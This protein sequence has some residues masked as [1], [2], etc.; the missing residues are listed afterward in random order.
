MNNEDA[1]RIADRMTYREAI[2]NCFYAKGIR[3]RKATKIKL[4]ELLEIANSLDKQES[5]DKQLTNEQPVEKSFDGFTFKVVVA[6][7]CVSCGKRI[8][9]DNIFLCKD[10]RSHQNTERK[11]ESEVVE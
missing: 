6:G 1:K 10:C 11:N 8:D 5:E 3:Y 2:M 7:N 9:D 4:N